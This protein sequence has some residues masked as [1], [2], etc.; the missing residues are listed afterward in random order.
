MRTIWTYVVLLLAL[1]MASF[2][3]SAQS[4]ADQ[5]DS[6]LAQKHQSGEFNGVALIGIDGKVKY[7][8]AF[9]IAEAERDLKGDTP[10]YL[11]SLAKSFTAMA[12]MMLAEKEKLAFDDPVV[13]Y[14]PEFPSHMSAITIRNLLNHTSGLPD[15]YAMG[16]YQDSMTNEMV[17]KVI[18]DLDD[19]EFTPGEKYSYSNTG[20]VLLSLLIERV[21]KDSYRKFIKFRIFEPLG[22]EYSE[23]FDGNQPKMEGRARGHTSDGQPNDYKALTTGAGGIYSMVDD[24]FLYDQALYSKILVKQETL[25]EAYTPAKLN[26]GESSY[27]GFGWVL[28]ARDPKIVQH[29]GSL[30]GFRTFFYRDTGQKQTIILLSNFT[31]DV[32]AIKDELVQAI[33]P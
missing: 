1:K 26:S 25:M 3:L 13:D 31:N 18:L 24:L 28:E 12:V 21:T 16:K 14:F 19:L 11:G 5:I 2:P 10:F 22:M 8:K 17:M 6:L 33:N 27:Y 9:G 7:R 20:Y 15:Y 30:A 4:T 32:S 29:S 23:V